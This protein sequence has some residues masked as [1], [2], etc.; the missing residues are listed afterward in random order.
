VMDWHPHFEDPRLAYG[1]GA[2]VAW[3]ISGVGQ[4]YHLRPC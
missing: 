1:I 4:L 3:L 2:D